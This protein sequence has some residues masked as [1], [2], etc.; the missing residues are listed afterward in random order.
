[1]QGGGRVLVHTLPLDSYLPDY[2]QSIPRDLH[3]LVC[4]ISL[5]YW[6]GSK[7]Y[8]RYYLYER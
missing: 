5:D 2:G 1:M 7:Y 4:K 6:G 8:H 3:F